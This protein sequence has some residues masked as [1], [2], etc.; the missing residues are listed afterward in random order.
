LSGLGAIT[1]AYYGTP[2]AQSLLQQAQALW[3]ELGD[4]GGLSHTLYHLGTVARYQGDCRTERARFAESLALWN[5]AADQRGVAASLYALGRWDREHGLLARAMER[6]EAALRLRRNLADPVHSAYALAQLGLC[7]LDGGDI[8][9][10]EHYAIEA[11]ALL[12]R[13]GTG[14]LGVAHALEVLGAVAA[15]RGNPLGAARR[16]G[17]TAALRAVIL[18]PPAPGEFRRQEE[19]IAAA[20]ARTDQAAWANAWTAGCAVHWEETVAEAMT[21]KAGGGSVAPAPVGRGGA[22][23]TTPAPQLLAVH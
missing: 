18:A 9:A 19:L 12:R 2:T 16:W 8:A 10:A 7:A 15:A 1:L 13:A 3:R 5:Q 14:N 20:R 21:G 23:A 4:W 22:H 17:T 11:L 6:L